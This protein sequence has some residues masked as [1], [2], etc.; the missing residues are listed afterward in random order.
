MSGPGVERLGSAP[1]PRLSKHQDGT[2]INQRRQFSYLDRAG[3]S[4]PRLLASFLQR[5]PDTRVLSATSVDSNPT[6]HSHPHLHCLLMAPWHHKQVALRGQ[7]G[8]MNLPGTSG[9]VNLKEASPWPVPLWEGGHRHGSRRC[10]GLHQ[11]L[12]LNKNP[13]L[14]L[15]LPRGVL[16]PDWE[17]PCA[18]LPGLCWDHEASFCCLNDSV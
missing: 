17:C 9:G 15:R 11:S 3:V 6:P 1:P 10:L 12:G 18:S 2:D 13:G 4:S 8:R 16:P 14:A 7:N 5:I